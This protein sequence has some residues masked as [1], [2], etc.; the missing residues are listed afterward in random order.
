MHLSQNRKTFLINVYAYKFTTGK[1]YD[2][3]FDK[4]NKSGKSICYT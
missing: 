4:A 2:K 1:L 3:F